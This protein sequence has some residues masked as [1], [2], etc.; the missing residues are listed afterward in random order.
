[1]STLQSENGYTLRPS[2]AGFEIAEGPTARFRATADD[3][4]WT[5][6]DLRSKQATPLR[7]ARD[8]TGVTW[9]PAEDMLAASS[10]S[11]DSL[12]RD[13]MRVLSVRDGRQF[14]VLSAGEGGEYRVY[15]WESDG[16]YLQV[17]WSRGVWHVTP[18]VAGRSL[19]ALDDIL[20][21]L[22]AELTL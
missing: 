11:G 7:R 14:R 19:D 13:V 1:M 6:T 12:E 5:V 18:T 15:G 8:W 10:G 20:V 17:T 4:G 22:A 9:C 16:A 2:G 3:D 21:L